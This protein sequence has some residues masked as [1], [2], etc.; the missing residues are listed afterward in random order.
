MEFL[1]NVAVIYYGVSNFNFLWN[2]KQY[3]VLYS[4]SQQLKKLLKATS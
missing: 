1:E 4:F 2:Q 3:K